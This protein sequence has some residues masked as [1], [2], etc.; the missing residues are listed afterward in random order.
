MPLKDNILPDPPG[1][2]ST[3]TVAKARDMYSQGFT[4]SRV[5]AHCN[6]S[7]GTLYHWLDGGPCGEGGAPLLPPLPRR[8]PSVMQKRR[9]LRADSVSLAARLVRT[10]ERQARDIELRLARPSAATPERERDVRML[11]ML[12]RA[13]RDLS[14]LT[15]AAAPSPADLDPVPT[16]IEEFRCELARR[17]RGFPALNKAEREALKTDPALRDQMYAQAEGTASPPRLPPSPA[18]IG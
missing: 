8:R 17:L 2:P 3:E 15:A 18:R 6:M 5:L 4:V 1:P 16:D 13:L 14:A 9:P 12:V 10:A 11:T 7:H